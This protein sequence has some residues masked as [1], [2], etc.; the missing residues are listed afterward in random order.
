[1][2]STVLVFL[3]VFSC[4]FRAYPADIVPTTAVEFRELIQASELDEVDRRL[5][6]TDLSL[7]EV[8]V[9]IKFLDPNYEDFVGLN[10]PYLTMCKSAYLRPCSGGLIT[11]NINTEQ[12][13]SKAPGTL[14]EFPAFTYGKWY[15]R[16]YPR[17]GVE[18]FNLQTG[19]LVKTIA[20]PRGAG[21]AWLNG[22]QL[23]MGWYGHGNWQ[24]VNLDT[25][26]V[27][28]RGGVMHNFRGSSLSKR[29]KYEDKL[30]VWSIRQWHQT[31]KAV[32][33]NENTLFTA[34]QVRVTRPDQ[35]TLV[36]ISG[37]AEEYLLIMN[38]DEVLVSTKEA[39]V[40]KASRK[41]LMQAAENQW[42]KLAVVENNK[43]ALRDAVAKAQVSPQSFAAWQAFAERYSDYLTKQEVFE[44]AQQFVAANPVHPGVTLQTSI[45]NYVQGERYIPQV[46]NSYYTTEDQSYS[47]N[48]EYVNKLV[49]KRREITSKGYNLSING[50]DRIFAIEN[51]SSEPQLVL[52]K[53]FWRG[54]EKKVEKERYCARS[55]LFSCQDYDERYVAKPYYSDRDY[56]QAFFIAP[57]GR[58]KHRYLL[59]EEKPESVTDYIAE[60]TPLGPDLFKELQV[61]F[62]DEAMDAGDSTLRVIERLSKREDLAGLRSALGARVIEIQQHMAARFDSEHRAGSAVALSFP[63]Q[64]DPDFAN[65]I[66]AKVVSDVGAFT[67]IVATPVG[68]RR[69]AV[70]KQSSG[71]RVYGYCLFCEW[72]SD[73]FK[74]EVPRGMDKQSVR[75]Q[76][77]LIQAMR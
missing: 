76:I 59:G 2:R 36:L 30:K 46:I 19:E 61:V 14:S 38:D 43:I 64:F 17:K 67:A 70:Y 20:W 66:T 69:V 26:R 1:M 24:V 45:D 35:P 49:S 65:V 34:S 3:L 21:R 60:V 53:S 13:V 41:A 50:F 77:S 31:P 57:G 75:K 11:Y 37:G 68:K 18:I 40:W 23:L 32:T 4:V 51:N 7:E 47:L 74:I 62:G 54:A 8:A 52:Y 58:V 48:G 56:Q 5:T 72:E 12:V 29:F 27:T 71:Y 16:A 44:R 42:A 25:L 9:P 55:G 73:S 39:G 33:L 28:E 10:A 63:D 15:A 22:N 6:V